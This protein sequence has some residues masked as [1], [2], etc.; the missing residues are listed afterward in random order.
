MT[1]PDGCGK[2]TLVAGVVVLDGYWYK[3][4]VSELEHGAPEAVFAGCAETLPR[5]STR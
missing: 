5:G 2:S 1:G 4:A 3:Y